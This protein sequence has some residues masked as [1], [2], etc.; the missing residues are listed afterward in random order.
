MTTPYNGDNAAPNVCT[1]ES[2]EAHLRSK[3]VLLNQ[4]EWRAYKRLALIVLSLFGIGTA[5]AAWLAVKTVVSSTAA[6]EATR[7]IEVLKTKASADANVIARLKSDL[8]AG[9][10]VTFDQA[11]ALESEKNAGYMLMG[12]SQKPPP[13]PPQTSDV[14]AEP[15]LHPAPFYR[16]VIRRPPQR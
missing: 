14:D 9:A 8:G 10:V 3:F 16:W 6:A 2:V 7:Q 4:D 11:I 12:H 5:S 1:I 13:N 15:L